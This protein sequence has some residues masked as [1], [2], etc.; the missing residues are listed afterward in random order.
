MPTHDEIKER[1]RYGQIVAVEEKMSRLYLD[2]YGREV[3]DPTPVAP[4]IGYKKQPSM[5]DHVRALVAHGL[6]ERAEQMGFETWEE[7]NDF[8]VGDDVE[9]ETP[10]EQMG[11]EGEL[12]ALPPEVATWSPDRRQAFM[13]GRIRAAREHHAAEQAAS[14]SKSPPAAAGG[15][16]PSQTGAPSTPSTTPQTGPASSPGTPPAGTQG[17]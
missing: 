2:Q 14:S 9:P 6:R 13:E 11:F 3:P 17:Q 5:V 16:E 7:A 12:G 15:R 1:M 8:D 10:Y 4:P